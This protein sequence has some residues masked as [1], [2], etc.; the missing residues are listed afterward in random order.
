M[1]QKPKIQSTLSNSVW[2]NLSEMWTPNVSH[3]TQPCF[4]SVRLSHFISMHT[5]CHVTTKT[6]KCNF[7]VK[8]PM[9]VQ[10]KVHLDV[11]NGSCTNFVHTLTHYENCTFVCNCMIPLFFKYQCELIGTI[12]LQDGMFLRK[13]F[14]TP[15]HLT[16]I[17]QEMYQTFKTCN[18]VFNFLAS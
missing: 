3:I 18:F 15:Q 1:S 7:H 4:L 5:P 17:L 12:K 10:G 8:F 9:K 16:G 11:I 6:W 2:F 13:S 14:L